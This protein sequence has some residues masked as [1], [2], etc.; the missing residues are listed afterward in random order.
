[1]LVFAQLFISILPAFKKPLV[2]LAWMGGWGDNVGVL[3]V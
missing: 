3:I 1:M 2:W